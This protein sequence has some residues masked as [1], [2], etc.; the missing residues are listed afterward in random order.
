MRRVVAVVGALI[1]VGIV[2]AEIAAVPLATRQIRSAAASSDVEA[3][4]IDVTAVRRPASIDLVQGRLRDVH[5]SGRGV[6]AGRL[7]IA[8][9]DMVVAE[10]RAATPQRIDAIV[11]IAVTDADATAY[12][13]A[14]APALAR[15]TVVFDAGI[16]RLSDER[17]PFELTVRMETRSDAIVLQPSVGDERLWTSLGL[18]LT[19][20]VPSCVHLRDLE[21]IDGRALARLDVSLDRRRDGTV[22]C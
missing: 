20:D 19:F 1:V 9:I 10:L 13:T 7:T 14:R 15:P 18:E 2:A 12:L 22:R 17:V 4:E 21:L 11:D 8:E 5:I 6:T 3:T 16:A